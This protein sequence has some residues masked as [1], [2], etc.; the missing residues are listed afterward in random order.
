[1][2]AGRA[3]RG[4]ER[5]GTV[6][7]VIRRLFP[8]GFPPAEPAP[9]APW[10]NA[11]LPA[12]ALAVAVTALY[13]PAVDFGMLAFDDPI[14]TRSR[15]ISGGLDPGNIVRIFTQL[16]EDDIIIPL[17]QLSLMADVELFGN[18]P[19][20]FHFTNIA[21]F[22]VDM[23]LLLLLLWRMTGSLAKSA[24][25]AG[26]VAFH[27][28]RVESVAWI[29]ER[30][31]VLVVLF[32]L[33]AIGCHV[34]FARSRKYRWYGAMLACFLLGML[35]KPVLVILPFLLLLLDFWP[36]GRFR[37]QPGEECPPPAWRRI[38]A[39]G[40]EKLPLLAISAVITIATMGLM[41]SSSVHPDISFASRVEHACSACF[42]YLGKTL[43]PRD[44]TFQYFTI[45]WQQYSGTL[46]PALGGMLLLTAAAL[47]YA[48]T[49]P[50]LLAG[51]CWFVIALFPSSGIVPVGMQWLSDRFTFVP[52]FGLMIAVAW[53]AGSITGTQ[54]RKAA[55]AALAIVILVLAILSRRQLYYWKDGA[56]LYGKGI[57]SSRR[58]PMYA[59]QYIVELIN[60]G[61]LQRARQELDL[62]SRFEMDPW[63]GGSI[64]T[65]RIDLLERMGDRNAAILKAREY[66]AKDPGFYKTRLR[67]ADNLLA[68]ERYEEAEREYRTVLAVPDLAPGLIR[69]AL[70]GLGFSLYT[71]GKDA[72]ALACYDEVLRGSPGSSTL[73]HRIGLLLARQGK[74]AEAMSSFMEAARIDPGNW[75]PRIGM[76]ELLLES[77]EVANSTRMLQEVARQFP[78]SSEA[79]FAQG[80]VMEEAGMK[81]EA[82][83]LYEN[84]LKAPAAFPETPSAVRRR[85]AKLRPA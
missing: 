21:I 81:A 24:L 17:T 34:A 66:L 32:L 59:T 16:P 74:A 33:L 69:H 63:F 36:L 54:A 35:A 51:W 61:A 26:L 19:R 72:E 76:A 2:G 42:I 48:G 40:A 60:V 70:E 27:P 44:L 3:R 39:L 49:R 28:L 73:H 71:L 20:G 62:I 13:W 50:Y 12:L 31:D 18:S 14:Y 84:A 83:S 56:A 82:R 6:G 4:E 55:Y 43:W 9:R 57:E 53:L 7:A 25:A 1:M 47:R 15:V 30:K 45:P 37:P 52:H 38:A 67:L 68:T 78:G 58:D 75:S 10:I 46:L 85:L 22:A 64:Q 11:L 41:G 79:L 29:T 65:N 8:D 77:G 80:R 23:A 5:Q